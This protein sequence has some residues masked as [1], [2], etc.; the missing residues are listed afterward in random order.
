MGTKEVIDKYYEHANAGNWDAWCDLF[1]DNMVMDEQLA[2]HIE[3]LAKLRPMMGG[4]KKMYSKFQNVAKKIV[5]SGDEAAVVSHISAASPAGEPIEANVMN[6]F[7]LEKGKIAYMA[8]FHDSRP[9]KPVLEPSGAA[10][11]KYPVIHRFMGKFMKLPK[12]HVNAYIVELEKSVIVIDTT[13]ALSSAKELRAKAE[14]LGKPIK[15]VL[16]THGHPDHYTGLVAFEDVPRIASQGCLQFAQEED[17]I[18]APTA[19]G[20]LGDDYPKKRVFPNQIVKNGDTVTFDG[21]TFTFRDMGPAESPSDG[22]WIVE[23]NGVKHAFVGDLVAKGCHCFF[24][25]GFTRE[26]NQVLER[27]RHEF[28]DSVQ[29]YIGHGDAPVGREAIDWQLGYNNAFLNAV[30]GLK[31]KSIPVP[32][33]SQDEVMAAVKKYLPDD[34]TEFLFAF[35]L[36]DTIAAHFPNRG[37]GMGR[38]KMFYLEQLGMLSQGKIEEVAVAHYRHDAEIVTFDGTRTGREAVKEYILETLQKHKQITFLQNEYLAESKDVVIFRA[39][40]KSEGR[41]TINA[42]DAFYIKDGK[43]AR[44]IALTLVPDADYGKLGTVWK[45]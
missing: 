43:I 24:R 30:E 20:F 33:A 27:M 34:S 1:A 32:Q 22:I 11:Q 40:V 5:V 3:G 15:A 13:L 23:K 10:P 21:V 41:G 31:D 17:V 7:K 35:E 4:M 36:G 26:W 44:H 25:D 16:L 45:Q 28:D 12:D 2:G 19:T 29:F 18:K 14:A 9:F 39:T 42:Q 38:G 8:N 6:Y 37:F